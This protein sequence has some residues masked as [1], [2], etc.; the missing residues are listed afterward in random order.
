M[1][2]YGSPARPARAQRACFP[3]AA[4]PSL[5]RKTAHSRRYARPAAR[6]LETPR[7][8]GRPRRNAETSACA[9]I[10]AAAQTFCGKTATGAQNAALRRR[11]S[12][13]ART[14]PEC[15]WERRRA[16]QPRPA[17]QIPTRR[18]NYRTNPAPE[19]GA[20]IPATAGRAAPRLRACKAFA[21]FPPPVVFF[22]LYYGRAGKTILL[23]ARRCPR[24]C[25]RDRTPSRRR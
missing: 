3:P 8:F 24:P 12:T 7:Q 2:E 4:H 9:R 18:S 6:R 11:E 21:W 23:T 15:A 19:A 17:R 20:D 13:P 10:P 5:R 14:A 22:V 16:F 1:E 25:R